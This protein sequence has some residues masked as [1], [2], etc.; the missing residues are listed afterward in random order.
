MSLSPPY[1]LEPDPP[2]RGEDLPYDDG[3]SLES[4]R[5][6]RQITLLIESLDLAWA[7]RRD[8]YVNGNMFVYCSET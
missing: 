8:F 4:E 1:K 2:P 3:E 5:H 7:A 6:V